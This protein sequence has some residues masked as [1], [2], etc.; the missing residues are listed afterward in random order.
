MTITITLRTDGPHSPEY[1]AEVADA[2]AE[3]VRVL[4]H[5]TMRPAGEALAYPADADA[6]IASL[7]GAAGSLPQLLRQ[8]GEWLLGELHA[9]RLLVAYGEFSGNPAAAVA[10]VVDYILDAQAA[11]DRLYRAVDAAHQVTSAISAE[12]GPAGPGGAR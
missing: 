1:T 2:L 5:A 9:D 6:V 3:C 10:A 7:S 11:A 12:R 8:L 4:N